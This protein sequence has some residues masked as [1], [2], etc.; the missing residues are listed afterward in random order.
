MFPRRPIETIRERYRLEPDIKDVF[1]E[2]RIDQSLIS[3]FLH[4]LGLANTS[5][6]QIQ[7]V[8]VPSVLVPDTE[9]G[10]KGRLKALAAE[11][12]GLGN[13]EVP[14][15][16]VVDRDFD[17][18]LNENSASSSR[19]LLRTDFSTMDMYLFDPLLIEELCNG[20]FDMNVNGAELLEEIG[21]VLRE[22]SLMFGANATLAAGCKYIPLNR[23]C[24]YE[25]D[26]GLQFDGFEYMKRYLQK[27]RAWSVREAFEAEVERLDLAA[28][29]D[30]RLWVHGRSFVPLLGIV[31]RAHGAPHDRCVQRR[32]EDALIELTDMQQLG[33]FSLFRA[34]AAWHDQSRRHC[35]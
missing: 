17:D 10:H 20:R 16:C 32:L 24:S 21:Q 22:A 11:L 19:L 14:G 5:V 34:I 13:V 2:G 23:C 12:E 26:G 33:R 7:Y 1:V 4:D 8:E 31:M 35:R 30:P 15:R 9:G 27:G 18:L 29:D 28:P 3:R 6:T 25:A